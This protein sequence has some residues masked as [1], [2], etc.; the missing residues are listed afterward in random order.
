MRTGYLDCGSGASGDM[1][2]GALL[3]AGWPEPALREVVAQ[4]GVPVRI[5]VGRV[6][7]RGV[8]AL[9]VQV[10]EEA[11]PPSRPYPVLARLLAGSRLDDWLRRAATSVF[12]RL[13]A[14]EATVH[15]RRIE[16]V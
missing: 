5:E 10:V 8:P 7:R 12:E 15:G 6:D 1:L 11:Q 3:G 16:E 2:L 9:R 13:A 14:V 4:L